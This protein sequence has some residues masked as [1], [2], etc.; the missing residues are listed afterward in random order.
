MAGWP[1]SLFG[2]PASG[3]MVRS[4]CGGSSSRENK[5]ALAAVSHEFRLMI[6]P[7]FPRCGTCYRR[8]PD[9]DEEYTNR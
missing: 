5:Q 3:T 1:P 6:V 4:V 9:S 7:S 8:T 2:W